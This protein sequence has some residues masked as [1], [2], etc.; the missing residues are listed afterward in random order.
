VSSK[1]IE[2]PEII[3]PGR[4]LV[5]AAELLT[6]QKRALG[7]WPYQWLFPGPNA[8][9]VLANSTVA[10]PG[11]A[12]TAVVLSYQV[13]DGYR[14]SLRAIV[15][16][17][18]GAGWNEGT[19]TG[20]SFTLLVQAAGTRKVDFLSGVL[21]HLGSADQPYPILGP[22][23]FAPNDLLEVTVTNGGGV[24]TGAS[25][26]SFAHLVGHTYPNSERVG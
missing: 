5:T 20:L 19:A 9:H 11:A 13:P 12:S 7:K 15:F 21:T 24:T 8:K 10:I 23:E 26:I 22:L 2:A 16:G 6:S 4:G 14:F 17:F 18:F 1:V 25:Q 3:A